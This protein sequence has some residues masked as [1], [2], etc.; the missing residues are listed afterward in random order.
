MTCVRG[1]LIEKRKKLACLDD[2]TPVFLR[3]HGKD[4]SQEL[5]SQSV[6]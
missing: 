4:Q 1:E 5:D 3:S 2:V 6:A